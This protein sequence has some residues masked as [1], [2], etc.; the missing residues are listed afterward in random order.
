AR[1]QKRRERRVGLAVD[2]PI[3]GLPVKPAKIGGGADQRRQ[4]SRLTR[5]RW[6]GMPKEWR[7]SDGNAAH[8]HDRVT[9]FYG[10]VLGVLHRGSSLNLPQR[11]PGW[12]LFAKIA[13]GINHTRQFVQQAA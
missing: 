1:R 7:V 13:G 2:H 5:H 11:R 4:K 9:I 12:I 3:I 8:A 6:V 10:L